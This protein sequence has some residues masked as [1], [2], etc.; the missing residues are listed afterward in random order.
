METNVLPKS[1]VADLKVK[2]TSFDVNDRVLKRRDR[3]RKNKV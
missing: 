1:Q 2:E 3:R